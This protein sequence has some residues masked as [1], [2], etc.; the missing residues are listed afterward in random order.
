MNDKLLLSKRGV[1]RFLN[2]QGLRVAKD[3]YDAFDED[4]ASIL[5]K[6]AKRTKGFKRSTVL[7]ND[8]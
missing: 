4:I 7:A 6:I 2:K 1:R 8:V 3:F 5:L